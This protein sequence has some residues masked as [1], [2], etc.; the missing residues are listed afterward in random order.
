MADDIFVLNGY[1][2]TER[3]RTNKSGGTKR[4][5]TVD[6][7]AEPIIHNLDPV[8]LGKGPAIAIA[9]FFRDSISA[10]SAAAAP[11]TIKAREG[12]RR[13]FDHAQQRKSKKSGK[14][15]G[16]DPRYTG[17]KL[18]PMQPNQTHQLFHDSGRL[19]KSIVAQL[20][21]DQYVVNVAANRFS[22]ETLDNGG[23]SAL[24]R[25]FSLLRTYV[26]QLG[27]ASMLMDALPVQAAVRAATAAMIHKADAAASDSSLEVLKQL[28]EIGREV[29]ELGEAVAGE[30]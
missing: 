16:G 8:A 13:A 20:A 17:G 10:I 30:G 21:G 14:T 26:P 5:Y 28:M 9:K 6:I 4:R 24:Q 12:A 23:T 19:I 25:I 7:K 29:D 22:P 18:G 15:I 3:S 11:R 2:L 27:D 1:G